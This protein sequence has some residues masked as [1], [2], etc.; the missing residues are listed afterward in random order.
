MSNFDYGAT[1]ADG[2]H[3]RYPSSVLLNADGKPDFKQPIRNKYRH[4]T[5]GAVTYMRGDDLCFTYATNPGFYGATFCV[6][7]HDHLPIREF[8]WEPDG[9]PMDQVSGEPGKDLRR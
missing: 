2:Q 7:C 4:R 6:G 3:E 8:D 5:C 1:K 9:V